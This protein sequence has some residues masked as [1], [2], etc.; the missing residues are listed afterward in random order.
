MVAAAPAHAA[1]GT[2]PVGAR[3]DIVTRT[4]DGNVVFQATNLEADPLVLT[5]SLPYV[6]AT[7]WLTS[8]TLWPGWAMDHNSPG[9]VATTTI[10]AQSASPPVQVAWDRRSGEGDMFVT[11]TAP[12]R[13]AVVTGIP[14]AAPTRA[15]RRAPV[16]PPADATVLRFG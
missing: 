8:A 15:A 3:L 16:E 1:S 6:N 5:I 2:L 9:I 7:T 10:A 12:G 11:M 4:G 14:W 13:S